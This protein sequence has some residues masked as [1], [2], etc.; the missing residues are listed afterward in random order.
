MIT[1][2]LLIGAGKWGSKYISTIN[3]IPNIKLKIANRKNWKQEIDN[4]ID[5]VIIATP[6]SSHI[7][8]AKYSLSKN[9]PTMIEKPLALSYDEA[10][11]LQNFN[12]PIL[13]NHLHLFSGAYQY[14]KHNLDGQI[15]HIYAESGDGYGRE[16]SALWDW[17][18][19]DLAMILD[20]LQKEPTNIE[21]TYDQNYYISLFFDRTTANIKVG[22]QFKKKTK[23]FR[24]YTDR[25]VFVYDDMYEHK[26]TKR[27]EPIQL[28]HLLP[29]TTSVSVFIEAIKGKNDDRLGLDLSLKILKILERCDIL[30]ETGKAQ[31]NVMDNL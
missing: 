8:I 10:T 18:P 14:I 26:L 6:P 16:Y 4:G 1:N 9:I 29:L 20:L 27:G 21:C 17:G 3:N 12:I 30:I 7:E 15:Q 28:N 2:L 13:V 23:Y 22:N 11:Q 25:S 5:G 24:L 31:E 19:H